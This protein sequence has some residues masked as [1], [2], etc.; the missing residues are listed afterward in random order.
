MSCLSWFITEN[1]CAGDISESLFVIWSMPP[2]WP[3]PAADI[4]A[5]ADAVCVPPMGAS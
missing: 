1:S 5:P 3:I 4:C 2:P